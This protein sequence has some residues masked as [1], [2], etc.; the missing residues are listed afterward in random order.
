MK[1]LKNETIDAYVKRIE[2]RIIILKENLYAL[3]EA[4]LTVKKE[5]DKLTKILKGLQK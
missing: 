1:K 4:V 3:E 5:L 2:K